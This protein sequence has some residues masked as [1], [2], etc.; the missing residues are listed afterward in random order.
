MGEFEFFGGDFCEFELA[1]E[2]VVALG[3]VVGGDFFALPDVA[4]LKVFA[5]GGGLFFAFPPVLLVEGV[6]FVSGPFSAQREGERDG[7]DGTGLA[8][9]GEDSEALLDLGLGGGGG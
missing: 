9:E 6:F 4:V 5:G 1:D 7:L 3:F 8:F 2:A